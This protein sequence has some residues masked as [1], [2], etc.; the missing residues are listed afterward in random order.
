MPGLKFIT[1]LWM[2][3]TFLQLVS[4]FIYLLQGDLVRKLKAENAPA[5]DLEVAI[6]EL[7]VRK[8]AF[9]TKV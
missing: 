8:K 3:Y 9:E 1:C 4:W 2:H 7:K 6:K 5:P